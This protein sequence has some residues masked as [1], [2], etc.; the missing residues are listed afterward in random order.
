MGERGEKRDNSLVNTEPEPEPQP[1]YY[2]GKPEPP[3]KD[4][5]VNGITV[6]VKF[7]GM[8]SLFYI[9]YLLFFAYYPY[10]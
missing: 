4:I 2:R 1:Y 5:I 10:C 3:T 9:S 6:K 7:C 8:A